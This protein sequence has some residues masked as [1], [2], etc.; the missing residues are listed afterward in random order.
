MKIGTIL[1]N[2]EETGALIFNEHVY[3]I[4]KINEIY[5]TNWK[6]DILDLLNANQIDTMRN[7]VESLKEEEFRHKLDDLITFEDTKFAPLYRNPQKIWGIGL[8][9]SEHA[10]D[11]SEVAPT[12]IPA[13]FMKAATTIIGPQEDIFIPAQS[14][15]TT[16]EAELGVIIKKR[17]KNMERKNWLDFVAGF[18]TIID[19][20]AEDI[21][22]KNPRYLTLSK[23]FDTFFSFGPVLFTPDEIPDLMDLNVATVINGAIHAKNVISNMQFPPDFLVSFH[24]KVMTLLPGDIISTGTPGA[25]PIKDGD[26][27]ECRIDG[28]PSLKNPVK[29]LA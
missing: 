12:S 14:R 2:D 4:R 10:N 26:I 16:G 8:N 13:S 11:L 22:R 27:I 29:D 21:L 15:K 18:T 17:C 9:Y 23:N 3:P 1:I 19:M 28:F 25:V 6:T 7:W 24:S 5:G 20:T